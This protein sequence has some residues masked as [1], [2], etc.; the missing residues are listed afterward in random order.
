MLRLPNRKKVK[1]FKLGAVSYTLYAHMKQ[2]E[3]LMP[4][5]LPSESTLKL[6]TS[7]I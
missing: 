3:H 1:G 4:N 6:R 2:Q 7:L 5:P